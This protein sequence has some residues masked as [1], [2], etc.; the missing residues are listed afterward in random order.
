MYE[1]ILMYNEVASAGSGP[2]LFFVFFYCS[3]L[4]DMNVLLKNASNE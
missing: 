1:N 4:E 2:F 3:A